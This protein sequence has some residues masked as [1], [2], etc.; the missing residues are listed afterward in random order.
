[1]EKGPEPTPQEDHQIAQGEPLGRFFKDS[2]SHTET[3]GDF[4]DSLIQFQRTGPVTGIIPQAGQQGGQPG[5]KQEQ[6]AAEAEQ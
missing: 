2:F 5:D 4:T 1:V 6:A 3:D